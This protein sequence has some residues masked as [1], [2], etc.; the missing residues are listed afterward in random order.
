MN[1]VDQQQLLGFIKKKK[2]TQLACVMSRAVCLPLK[3]AGPDGSLLFDYVASEE[4]ETLW[5]CGGERQRVKKVEEAIFGCRRV[6]VDES[7][8]QQEVKGRRRKYGASDQ[9][10]VVKW[11]SG[12]R[13]EQ[14]WKHLSR[15]EREI[16]W[17]SFDSS[18]FHTNITTMESGRTTAWVANNFF[19]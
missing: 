5:S 9:I 11:K 14:F 3:W 6:N 19:F 8:K 10:D 17:I 4:I 12:W 1:L 7:D 16:L 13:E 18:Y 15:K 2:K